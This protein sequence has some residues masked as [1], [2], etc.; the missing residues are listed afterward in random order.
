MKRPVFLDRFRPVQTGPL[1]PI[2]T[3]SN[4]A[5]GHVNWLKTDWDISN[6]VKSSSKLI[7]FIENFISLSI[8][9]QFGCSWATFEAYINPK[10]ITISKMWK[11]PVKTRTSLKTGPDRKYR[12][13]VVQSGLLMV[14]DIYRPVSVLVFPKIDKRPDWTGLLNTNTNLKSITN[15]VLDIFQCLV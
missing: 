3:P 9:A 4:V 12:S 2:I 8:L 6:F 13:K 5:Q 15:M 14:W 11:K 7:W 10:P 1:Y